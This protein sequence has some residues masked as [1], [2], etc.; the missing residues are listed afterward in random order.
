L[1]SQQIT[2][3]E[4]ELAALQAE[5]DFLQDCIDT[6]NKLPKEKK[7]FSALNSLITKV[8]GINGKMLRMRY[9]ISRLKRQE[10]ETSRKQTSHRQH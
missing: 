1:D 10:I 5:H 9:E 4:V 8:H 7:D 3:L 2:E 6:E